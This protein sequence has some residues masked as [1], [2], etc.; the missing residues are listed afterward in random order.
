LSIIKKHIKAEDE[1]MNLETL[2]SNIIPILI[3]KNL[4]L[5]RYETER[6]EICDLLMNIFNSKKF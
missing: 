3:A 4:P 5:D 2:I 6:T 1:Q